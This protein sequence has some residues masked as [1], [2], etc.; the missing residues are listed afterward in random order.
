MNITV[1]QFNPLS[2]TV[3]HPVDNEVIK[4]V[5]QGNFLEEMPLPTTIHE[6][7][8]KVT[9]N[10]AVFWVGAAVPLGT[11]DFTKIQVFFHPTVVQGNDVHARD[12][13]YPNFTGG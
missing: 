4:P 1:T 6:L 3:P 10:G 12:V 2:L 8:F 13:D 9:K 7:L 11:T 5:M